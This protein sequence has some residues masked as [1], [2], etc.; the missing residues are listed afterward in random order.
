MRKIIVFILSF[1]MIL[2][3]FSISAFAVSQQEIDALKAQRDILTQ[4]R[5]EKQETVDKLEAEQADILERKQALDERNMI[6]IEQMEL[7]AEEIELYDKMIAEKAEELEEAVKREQDQLQKYRERVRAMEENGEFSLLDIVLASGNMAEL[8][9]NLDDI[10]EIMESDRQLEDE[11]IEARKNTESVKAEYETVK[12]EIEEKQ[13]VLRDEQKGLEEE[14]LEASNLLLEIKNDLENREAEYARIMEAEDEAN[15]E[16]ERLIAQREKELEEER[17]QQEAQNQAGQGGNSGG[18]VVTGS[19]SFAWPTPGVT[20]ITSRFG[21]RIHPVT[22]GEKFHSGLDIGASFGTAIQ[23]SDSGTVILAGVCG[24]Y[25]NCVMVDHGNGYTTVYGHMSSI[26]VS[27]DQ[28][29]S[30]GEVLG[31]VGDTGITS[32]PHLHFE[33]RENNQRIDPAQ[34]FSGLTYSPTA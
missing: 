20:Y 27:K 5:K 26:A 18:G 13:Q 28:S 30:Q 24:G 33:I 29:V 32:G 16:I 7:N 15:A 22:G 14:I 10:G 23:A 1:V 2:N 21:M 9:A 6:A 17:K 34:F 25:G 4:Q 11:Y 19:G 3:V 12:A 8:L 31:Y